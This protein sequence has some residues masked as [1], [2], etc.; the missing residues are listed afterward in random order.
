M[1]LWTVDHL[2]ETIQPYTIAFLYTITQHMHNIRFK[3]LNVKF[4]IIDYV[5]G[6]GETPYMLQYADFHGKGMIFQN[7]HPI[8]GIFFFYIFCP[9][10]VMVFPN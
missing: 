4:I 7:H 9:K 6:V 2:V 5:T 3:T 8:T 10:N 1:F